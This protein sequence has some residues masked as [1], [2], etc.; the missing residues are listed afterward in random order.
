MNEMTLAREKQNKDNKKLEHIEECDEA[1]N[2]A[3]EVEKARIQ[4]VIDTRLRDRFK[5]AIGSQKMSYIIRKLIISYIEE[6]EKKSE[7][8]RDMALAD[9]ITVGVINKNE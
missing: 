5:V 6:K 3:N 7:R 9:Y 4:F 1:M 2:V 8:V